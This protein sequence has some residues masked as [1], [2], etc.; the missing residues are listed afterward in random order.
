[1][2]IINES[3]NY[4]NNNAVDRTLDGDEMWG[5][6]ASCRCRLI[7]GA[8]RDEDTDQPSEVKE[9][10]RLWK[11]GDF[12]A[13]VDRATAAAVRIIEQ[14]AAREAG[15]SHNDLTLGASARRVAEAG[16]LAKAIQK[17]VAAPATGIPDEKASW[18]PIFVPTAQEG[19]EVF[20]S[21]EEIAGA[22]NEAW[23][24]GDASAARRK[25]LEQQRERTG[26]KQLPWA[27]F[28]ALTA[29]GRSGERY[30]YLQ[31]CMAAREYGPKMH[32]KRSLDRLA[33][34]WAAETLPNSARWFLDT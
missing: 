16:A 27:R 10:L 18:A 21:R 22:L 30:E 15:D 25:I 24:K 9:R 13:L 23:G 32:L 2:T 12:E 1:M 11:N 3:R 28:R 5:L 29:P 34:M 31:D 20:P 14:R 26:K 8:L 6:L 17:F 7:L 19:A 4:F 33:C